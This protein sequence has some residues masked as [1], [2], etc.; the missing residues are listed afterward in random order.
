M[1]TYEGDESTLVDYSQEAVETRRKSLIEL[2]NRIESLLEF[3][4]VGVTLSDD[5]GVVGKITRVC[6]GAS[7]WAN[8]T[9][10]V[11][12]KGKGLVIEG[13]KIV[14]E[15]LDHSISDGNNVHHHKNESICLVDSYG[16]P[17]N[18]L[19]YLNGTQTRAAAVRIPRAVSRYI[20]EC[21][22]EADANKSVVEALAL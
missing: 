15:N 11:T 4:P 8:R 10:E 3:I 21:K 18:R 5:N 7:Q 20:S 6:T 2:R 9:W 12:I 22:A 14:Y 1:P 19:S 17:G 13:K 16:E